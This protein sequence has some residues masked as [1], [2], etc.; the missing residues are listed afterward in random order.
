MSPINMALLV[1]LGVMP[2]LIWLSL[3]LKEDRH[4]EPKALI[5]KT[6]LM[7]IIISPLAILLQAGFSKIGS[8]G[9]ADYFIADGSLFFLWAAF[10]EEFLK[11]YAVRLV[12]LTDPAFYEPGA[13]LIYMTPAG[14]G[15][16]AIDKILVRFRTAP[17]TGIS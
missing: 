2:S 13:A 11:F 10:V 8:W 1:L 9:P 15:F 17:R 5:T 7:G 6:F 14:R 4:P 12:A 16:S 3:F